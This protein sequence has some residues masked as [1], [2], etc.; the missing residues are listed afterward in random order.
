VTSSVGGTTSYWAEFG[1]TTAYGRETPHESVVLE[2]DTPR[3]VSLRLQGL[4][5][6]TRYHYRVCAAD[7]EQD[8]TRGV[9]GADRR[10]V[11]QSVTCGQTITA[12]VR[13][14]GNLDCFEGTGPQE[15]S[16]GLVIGADGLDVNLAGY[17]IRGEIFVG[18]GDARGIDNS[19][20]YDDLVV[21]NGS[22]GG[23]GYAIYIEGASRNA[24][25]GVTAQG[26]PTGAFVSAGAQNE[27]RRS[28]VIG[29]STAIYAQTQQGF[30][31]TDS[32]VSGFFSGAMQIHGDGGLIARNRVETD[33]LNAIA[34]SGSGNRV[35]DNDAV[36]GTFGVILV[37]GSANVVSGNDASEGQLIQP[38]ETAGSMGDGIF[39]SSGAAGTLVR[40]NFAHANDGDGIEAPSAGTRL[41]DNRAQTN[42]DLGIRAGTGVIDLGGNTASGNGNPLQCVNVFCQ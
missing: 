6:A 19:G 42:G 33:F 36:G 35:L 2:K 4:E 39:V 3:G 38:D 28:E 12:D 25:R 24:I 41:R 30:T 18:G 22:L 14:T 9:C 21:R 20:G 11:T 31:V 1:T 10:L 32:E 23:W 26:S 37:G 34:V 5:R 29:R 40:D 27:I 7:S 8:Q 13:L 15:G 16:S 17:D